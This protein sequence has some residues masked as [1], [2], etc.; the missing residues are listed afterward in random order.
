MYISD[1]QWGRDW[2]VIDAIRAM[3]TFRE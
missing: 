3:A 1:A 2:R